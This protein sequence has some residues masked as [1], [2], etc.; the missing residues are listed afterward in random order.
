[1]SFDPF[2]GAARRQLNRLE[3]TVSDLGLKFQELPECPLG[4]G[5]GVAWSATAFTVVSVNFEESVSL[6]NVVAGVLKSVPQD[7]LA[8]LNTC[9]LVTKDHPLFATYLH[10]ASAGWDVLV[11]QRLPVDLLESQSG[12]F[13]QLLE[14]D[15]IRAE[16]AVE[17]FAAA[18][19]A[20]ARHTWDADDLQ[21]L[22]IR[23]L[24]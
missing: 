24:A 2:D 7:R 18:G 8:I 3:A 5:F 12:F 1:V 11:G 13:G 9:N 4:L 14:Y 20:S 19:I 21:H 6:A 15:P 23:G 17:K 22:L 16:S 10:D